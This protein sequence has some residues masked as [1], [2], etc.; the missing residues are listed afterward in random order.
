MRSPPAR[1][2]TRPGPARCSRSWLETL[3]GGGEEAGGLDPDL[4]TGAAGPVVV[5]GAVLSCEFE[6]PEGKAGGET[7]GL[8][9][10]MRDKTCMACNCNHEPF[11]WLVDVTLTFLGMRICKGVVMTSCLSKHFGLHAV[12]KAVYF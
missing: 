4:E 7:G 3:A 5:F 6:G 1:P 8:Y 12:G 11:I 10:L 2:G 9:L